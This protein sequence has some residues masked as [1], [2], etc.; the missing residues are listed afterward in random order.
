MK[1]VSIVGARPQFIKLAPFNR[2]VQSVGKNIVHVIVHTGQHYDEGLSKR[3]LTDCDIPE[4]D[5][6]LA[7]GS[8]PHGRQTALMMEALEPLLERER[9]KYV[10][11]YGDTNSTLAGAL[12]ASKLDMSIVHIES[13]LRSFNRNIPE[14][15]NRI[16]ADHLSDMLFA[17]SSNAKDNLKNEGLGGRAFVT[18]DIMVDSLEMLLPLALSE[19]RVVDE[20]QLES[21]EFN[22]LTLHRP[23][24][25]DDS[26]RLEN[27]LSGVGTLPETTVFVVHPRTREV[28]ETNEIETPDRI[29]TLPP[30]GYMDFLKLEYSAKRIITDSGGVQKEALFLKTPCITLRSATEWVETVELGWNILE[31]ATESGFKDRVVEFSP[32]GD[33][34]PVYGRDVAQD[35]VEILI[36]GGL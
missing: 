34:G 23:S 3:I 30:V 11:V 9:P 33:P 35:M 14:E 17:P 1:L 18:G 8:H 36:N 24:N 31:D 13:G 26:D 20:N 22:L 15:V 10:I 25:V 29:I 28:I 4:P 7:V 32:E 5:Y 27:I 6:N 2:A 12:V 19:S 16:V 21:G